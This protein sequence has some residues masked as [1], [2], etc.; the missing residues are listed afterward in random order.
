VFA[1]FQSITKCCLTPKVNPP[2]VF[3][4]LW[5]L[6]TSRALADTVNSATWADYFLGRGLYSKGELKVRRRY[7]FGHLHFSLEV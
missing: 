3:V 2:L 1:C 6:P 7:L 4:P 5:T